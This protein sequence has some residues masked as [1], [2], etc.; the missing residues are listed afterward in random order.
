M[1][2]VN[3]P[4]NIEAIVR[5]ALEEDI[6]SGDVTTNCTVPKDLWLTG[7][8]VAK[9]HGVVAGLEIAA[10]AFTLLD[11][12]VTMD[13][14]AQD[15]VVVAPKQVIATLAGP[16]RALLTGERTALNILQRMSGIATAT[17]GFVE[18][19]AGTRARILD[20]RKTAPGLRALDKLAVR[21]GGGMNHRI[22]LYD[23]VMIKNNHIAACGGSLTEAVRRVREC[24]AARPE[25]SE[26]LKIEVEVRDLRELEEALALDVDI[27]MLDNM[28]LEDMRRAVDTVN[29][30]VKLEASGNVTLDNARA[31]AETGVDYISSGALTHSVRALDIS[32]WL[33]EPN[34]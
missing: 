18:A 27:I 14:L 12:R 17:R 1:D 26:R 4:P 22:G 13:R 33:D 30:R 32:L 19:V 25:G 3:I 5:R 20:T 24:A 2:R 8:F 16:A 9:A 21:I 28:S 10:L 31:I 7:R 29:G 15:G 6:G 11:E 23:M 34:I